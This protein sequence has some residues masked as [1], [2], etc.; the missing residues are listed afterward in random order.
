MRNNAAMSLWLV[1]V[2]SLLVCGYDFYA[3]VRGRGHNIVGWVLGAVMAIIA[4][5]ALRK[6][7]RKDYSNTWW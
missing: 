1:F 2:L 3:A 7:M 4:L 6:L 5:G